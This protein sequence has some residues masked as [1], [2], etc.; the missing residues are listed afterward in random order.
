[1]K[2]AMSCEQYIGES[3]IDNTLTRP[4]LHNPTEHI[5][6]P[7]D[8]MKN[9][10][11]LELPPSPGFEF[12]LTAMDVFCRYL[13][14]YRT[15]RQDAKPVA[16]VIINNMIKHAYLPATFIFDKVTSLR[17]PSDQTSG[18]SCRIHPTTRHNKACK[19]IGKLER[20]HASLRNAF[21]I[22][23]T[24][25]KSFWHK[26]FNIAFLNYSTS[27]HASIGCESSRVFHGRS[28]YNVL[29]LKMSLCPQKHLP[30][31]HKMPKISLNK[32]KFSSKMFTR[33]SC[34]LTS[35]IKIKRKRTMRKPMPQ[36]WKNGTLCMFC[37]L[38]Q[39]L[40]EANFPSQ[41]LDGLV[42]TMLKKPYQATNTRYGKLNWTKTGA[43]SYETATVHA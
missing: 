18:W 36:N 19:T 17:V 42:T 13:F 6:A 24:A 41:A 21:R 26:Y 3:G 14:A 28:P 20:K 34:K 23:T 31:V 2:W 10:L 4:N 29:E 43:S 22:E 1:M 11:I 39:I 35:S 9:D 30:Q 15:S 7:E 37:N 27:C 40:K 32:R 5:A 12:I 38:K 33:T 16:R 25:R 8:A